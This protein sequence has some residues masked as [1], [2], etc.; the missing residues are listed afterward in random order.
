MPRVLALLGSHD[1]ACAAWAGSWQKVPV[2]LLLP[3][4]PQMLS[5][6]DAAEGA[7][8]L[9]VLKART[10]AHHTALADECQPSWFLSCPA[11]GNHC[12]AQSHRSWSHRHLASDAEPL[13]CLLPATM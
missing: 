11:V 5:L 7:A 8:L 13:A 2:H 4:G 10:P 9:P 3:W 6:L 12:I 1:S